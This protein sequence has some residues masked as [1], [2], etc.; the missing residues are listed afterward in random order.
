MSLWQLW[1]PC[2]NF[3]WEPCR[4]LR[5]GNLGNLGN[6]HLGT[7]GIFTLEILGPCAWQLGNLYLGTFW[8]LQESVLG[9]LGDLHLRAFT[10]N[11][12]G[13]LHS[14]TL[15]TLGALWNL[16]LGTLREPLPGEPCTSCTNLLYSATL[17]WEPFLGNFMGTF[18]WAPWKPLFEKCWGLVGTC[19]WPPLLGSLRHLYLETLE[20][21]FGNL[22]SGMWKPVPCNFGNLGTL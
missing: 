13:N 3:A 15:A 11:C 5:H 21:L 14:V 22:Y 17:T 7:L 10:R 20:T 16:Y 18:T 8:A 9:N 12:C 1:E 4:N 2:G 19:A 6:L